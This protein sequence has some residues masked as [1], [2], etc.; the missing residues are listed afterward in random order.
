MIYQT[1]KYH[2]RH[3]AYSPTEAQS[4]NKNGWKDVTKE[5]FYTRIAQDEP[6]VETVP[7]ITETSGIID[8]SAGEPPVPRETL[9]A[10]YTSLFGKPPH[11]NMKDES[12][13][14]AIDAE[15]S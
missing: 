7:T 8:A 14:A 10:D 5:E 6:K 4:N 1:H 9:V 12:I 13:K 15:I 2:G 3:I 11:F